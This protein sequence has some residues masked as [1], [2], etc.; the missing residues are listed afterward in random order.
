MRS[1]IALLGA[2]L[3]LLITAV[4]VAASGGQTFHYQFSGKGAEGFWTT[5]PIDGVSIVN[6]VY[7]DTYIGTATQS[8]KDDGSPATGSSLYIVSFSYKFDKKRNFVPLTDVFAFIEG[9]SLTIDSKLTKANASATGTADV[10]QI[11]ANWNYSCTRGTVS[12]NGTWV[13]Q[14]SLTRGH[15]TDTFGIAGQVQSTFRGSFTYRNATASAQV[16]LTRLS[17]S[18]QTSLRICTASRTARTM[19][20]SAT[21]AVADVA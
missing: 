18:A 2:V 17:T 14:G 6:T 20:T 12:V 5:Y 21:A 1:R 11:D 8:F 3:A 10:C 13:G 7:R 15:G 19:F 16:S 4:P 9:S